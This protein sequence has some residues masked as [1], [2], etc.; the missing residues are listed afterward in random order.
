MHILF[1]RISLSFPFWSEMLIRAAEWLLRK[2]L[3]LFLTRTLQCDFSLKCWWKRS[4]SSSHSSLEV[5]L[6]KGARPTVRPFLSSVWRHGLRR[7]ECPLV[8]LSLQ[9]LPSY[10]V[11]P[12][13]GHE[14]PAGGKRSCPFLTLSSAERTPPQKPHSLGNH[15]WPSQSLGPSSVCDWRTSGSQLWIAKGQCAL[16]RGRTHIKCF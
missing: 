7:F 15:V 12:S 11:K 14:C 16:F 10:L 6:E 9:A 5:K 8:L 1:K 4:Q 3:S 2:G 13:Q